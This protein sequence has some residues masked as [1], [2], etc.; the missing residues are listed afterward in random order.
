MNNM[1]DVLLTTEAAQLL[2]VTGNRVRQLEAAGQL[3]AS[4]TSGGVRLFRRTDVERLARERERARA[5][6]NEER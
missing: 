5:K 2:H 6:R 4:R 1:N 3:P